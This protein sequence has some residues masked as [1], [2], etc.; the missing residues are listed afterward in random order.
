MKPQNQEII[1]IG[2]VRPNGWQWNPQQGQETWDLFQRLS[3]LSES[4]QTVLREAADVLARSVDPHIDHG[5][6]TGLVL[7]YVQSGKTL[8]FTTVAT[9]ARDNGY[10]VVVVIAGTSVLLFDQSCERLEDDLALGGP[11]FRNRWAVFKNPTRSHLQRLEAALRRW[12]DPIVPAQQ[13]ATVLIEVMKHH[14]HLQHLNDLL[15]AISPELRGAPVLI[16]DDEAD[17]AGLNTRVRAGDQSITYQRLLDLRQAFA[18]HTHLQYTATPQAPLLISVIDQLS[19]NFACVLTPGADYAGGQAFFTNGRELLRSIPDTDVS[20]P[21]QYQGPVPPNSLLFALR[22]FLI[23]IAVG[24]ITDNGEGNRSMLVHPSRLQTDHALFTQWIQRALGSWRQVLQASEQDPDRIELLQEFVP[25]YNDLTQTVTDLPPWNEVMQ[26]LERACREAIIVEV[27]ARTQNTPEINYDQEY[28]HIVVGGQ[29][30]DRGVTIQGLTV[31]YMPRDPG[32]GNADAIQQRARF[33]GYKYPYLGYCR[34]FLAQGTLNAFTSYVE[35]EEHM[36]RLLREFQATGRPLSEWRR[37]FFLD[38]GL[39]PTRS[40]VLALD[41]VQGAVRDWT[42]TKSPLLP[43]VLV[44]NRNAVDQFVSQV[45]FVGASDDPR[46]APEERN[47]VATLT[48]Q[49]VYQELLTQWRMPVLDPPLMGALLSLEDWL[50]RNPDSR[51]EVYLMSGGRARVRN[52]NQDTGKIQQLFQGRSSTY[53]GDRQIRA[54]DSATVQ[55]HRLNLTNAPNSQVY[56][57]QEVPILAIWIPHMIRHAWILGHMSTN[58]Q[59]G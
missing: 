4:A 11:N 31:T 59:G 19:P 54:R 12:T 33:F 28:A 29:A 16:I 24:F 14:T 8:S 9:L 37:M 36:R 13:R 21:G 35:H 47:Q 30:L 41:Y 10:R 34:L 53:P 40:N 46:I 43:E 38:R 52:A 5:E 58:R 27:N 50:H 48:L 1:E 45:S 15:E 20:P 55:I 32:E 39:R 57:A 18:H 7:G 2:A 26:H 23:E 42:V 49:Q 44:N 51:C 6:A 3:L 17:Q 56:F 25:A 22:L